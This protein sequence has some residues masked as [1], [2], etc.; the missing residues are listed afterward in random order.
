MTAASDRPQPPTTKFRHRPLAVLNGETG[1]LTISQSRY[2]NAEAKIKA[3]IRIM[4]RSNF[5][6]THSTASSRLRADL[7]DT[8]GRKNEK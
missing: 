3:G 5:I 2:Q 6:D 4:T 7:K 1:N 8:M